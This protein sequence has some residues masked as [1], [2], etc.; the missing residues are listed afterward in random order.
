MEHNLRRLHESTSVDQSISYHTETHA[1]H[2]RI[3]EI[4]V[5]ANSGGTPLSKPDL[6]LATLA[7][8]WG[9]ENAREEIN[10]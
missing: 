8:H 2:E 9:T 6:L 3:L 5:R 7:L 4:F 10:A 1:D